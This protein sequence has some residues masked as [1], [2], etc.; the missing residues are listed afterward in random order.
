VAIALGS[1]FNPHHTPML[2][3]QTVVA[4]ACG[5]LGMTIE[6]ALSA[7]TINGAHSLGCA[8]KVGSLEPGKSADLLILNAGNYR[9][10]EHSLGTNLVHLTMKRGRFIYKEG[11]VTPRSVDDLIPHR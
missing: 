3:M 6:E 8:E 10:L 7:A 4:L 2:S 1:N 9:D 5:R 11:E